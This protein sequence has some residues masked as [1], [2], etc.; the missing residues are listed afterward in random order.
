M[1]DVELLLLLLS[2]CT[3][4]LLLQRLDY[5]QT[6]KEGTTSGLS[7]S[8][9]SQNHHWQDQIKQNF[10]KHGSTL[11]RASAPSQSAASTH[12]YEHQIQ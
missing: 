9:L 5:A 11:Q 8:R 4:S 2:F 3:G 6:T 12:S 10:H 1:E 7:Y